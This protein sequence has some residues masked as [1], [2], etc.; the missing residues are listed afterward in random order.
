MGIEFRAVHTPH[1]IC[2]FAVVPGSRICLDWMRAAA[3]LRTGTVF[4]DRKERF[5]MKRLSGVGTGLCLCLGLMAMAA[6]QEMPG[7]PK[8]LVIQRE[9][10]KPGRAGSVHEKS[11]SAF[12]RAM[13]AAKWPTH[14]FA[15]ES[16]SGPSRA[17]FLL[18]YSS[19]AEWEKDN[20]A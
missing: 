7:P 12:V 16:M 13:A 10:L 11:E 8:V 17:L 1:R 19:F 2:G 3:C 5:E 20:M 4:Q 18:G 9:Y 6:A 14:Y 15:V